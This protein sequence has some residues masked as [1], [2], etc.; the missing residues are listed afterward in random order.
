MEAGARPTPSQ[1]LAADE[2]RASPRTFS[3]VSLCARSGSWGARPGAS[4]SKRKCGLCALRRWRGVRARCAPRRFVMAGSDSKRTGVL[5]RRARRRQRRA[6]KPR[7]GGEVKRKSE[8]SGVP[9]TGP[10]PRRRGRGA[11]SGV[12]TV[13]SVARECYVAREPAG[14]PCWWFPPA[15]RRRRANKQPGLPVPSVPPDVTR[16]ASPLGPL[17]SSANL[18]PP[19]TG[20]KAVRRVGL[21]RLQQPLRQR[22]GVECDEV[23]PEVD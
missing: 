19:A 13:R 1:T 6:E 17:T 5:N 21:R 14:S 12:A 3:S 10:G 4:A 11:R 22:A 18:P 9:L 16:R 20:A 23:R 15:A 8:R 2:V 7:I